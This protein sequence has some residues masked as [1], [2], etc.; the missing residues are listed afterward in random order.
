MN[1][2]HRNIYLHDAYFL[3]DLLQLQLGRE[4]FAPI[5]DESQQLLSALLSLQQLDLLFIL[6][7]KMKQRIVNVSK[8]NN[9]TKERRRC[10]IVDDE[11]EQQVDLE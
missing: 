1:I 7:F 4:V 5:A 11:R 6:Y 3:M 10:Y 2:K 9:E 8:G